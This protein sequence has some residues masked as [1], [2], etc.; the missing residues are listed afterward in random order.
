MQALESCLEKASNLT[1]SSEQAADT[2][3]TRI[4]ARVA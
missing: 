3:L 4:K 1:F 2:V